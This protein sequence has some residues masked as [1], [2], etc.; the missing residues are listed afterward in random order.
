MEIIVATTMNAL[1]QAARENEKRIAAPEVITIR[2]SQG[3]RQRRSLAPRAG[4]R[5]RERDRYE[6]P[7]HIGVVEKALRTGGGCEREHIA[8]WERQ[9]EGREAES[10][11][12]RGSDRQPPR[13]PPC[14]IRRI[15]VRRH[16][17]AE[18]HQVG[19]N[20]DEEDR[21]AER[22]SPCCRKHVQ[23]EERTEQVDDEGRCAPQRQAPATRERRGENDDR[24]D[25][26]GQRGLAEHDPEDQEAERDDG[27]VPGDR[28]EQKRAHGDAGGHHHLRLSAVLR[29]PPTRP[30][31]QEAAGRSS[32]R[33]L[34]GTPGL[35]G[36]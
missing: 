31:R 12:D 23:H 2:K 22:R 32:L 35:A 18:G 30:T 1:S 7:E 4:E 26:I 19:G 33:D 5:Q 29:R 36:P 10:G 14:S 28:K 9:E 13:H 6:R 20:R 8:A 25:E 34:R 27:V 17:Q 15:D 21:R 11:R 24:E 16:P 3:R